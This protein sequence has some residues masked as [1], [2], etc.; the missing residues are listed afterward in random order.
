MEAPIAEPSLPV[1][2]AAVITVSDRSA[3]GERPDVSGPLAVAAL[4]AAGF[5]AEAQAIPDGAKS[6]EQA[7]RNAIAAG[8]RL[9]VTTGGTGIGPRDRTP[10]G[11]RPVLDLEVTGI[12]DAM[13][14]AGSPRTPHAVLS[15]GLVGVVNA[16]GTTKGAVIVNLPGSP[17]GVA[18]GLSLLVRLV[19]HMLAQLE[20]DDH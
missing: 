4:T 11:T 19:P 3:S 9:V 14:A 13:R 15:R 2:V 6:V 16:S 8:A 10:E 5:K 17:S 18:E 20:G 12:A 1:V 7:L